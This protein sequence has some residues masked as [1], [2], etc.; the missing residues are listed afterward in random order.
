MVDRD[1]SSSSTGKSSEGSSSE[2]LYDVRD[3]VGYV[4]LNRPAARNALT[5]DMYEGLAD[6]CRT[7]PTDGSL[8]AIVISGAGDRAF[9]A[10]TDI[11]LFRDFNV[12]QQ[13]LD[14][15]ARMDKVFT[16]I[17]QCPVTTIAVLHGACTGGG[18]AIAVASDI[19]IAAKDLKFGVP[20]ART[21]GNCLAAKNLGRMSALIG[22][23]RV[24]E[25][26]FTSRLLGA[27]E[28]MSFGLATEILD[29]K[30]AAMQRGT[31]LAN[32]VGQHAPLTLRA[33]KEA[34]RR[35]AL[36]QNTVDDSDL[37]TQCYMSDDFKEGIE[38]FLS[39]RKPVWKGH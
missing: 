24:L 26:L 19:R 35:L 28:A 5:Y 27:E 23:G 25:M 31:E 34:L 14:Y 9:A 30:D 8:R 2:I 12:P 20:I 29:D 32:L 39:K 1:T 33:T 38:A 17:E 3:R 21:L 36:N 22:A 37:I 6:I 11:A 16:D 7:A 13:A 4:T 18:A 15:E 10:G